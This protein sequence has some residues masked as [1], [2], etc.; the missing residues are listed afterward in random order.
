M[1]VDSL[2]DMGRAG[3]VG[4]GRIGKPNREAA[5]EVRVLLSLPE[6]IGRIGGKI[7]QNG[8]SGTTVVSEESGGKFNFKG[9]GARGLASATS[10]PAP[11]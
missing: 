3:L 9:E 1:A 6:C 4:T 2:K 10:E 5:G 11:R 7:E 8:T